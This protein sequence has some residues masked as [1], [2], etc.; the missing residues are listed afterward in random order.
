MIHSIF[1]SPLNLMPT[2]GNNMHCN[3]QRVGEIIFNGIGFEY[4]GS[5]FF[6]L[7]NQ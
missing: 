6:Q 7:S 1:N 4:N 3:D 5:E 2:P